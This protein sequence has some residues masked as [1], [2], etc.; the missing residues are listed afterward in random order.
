MDD[1]ESSSRSVAAR[2]RR[3]LGRLTPTERRPA[4]T[5]LSNY[6]VA[7]LETVAQFAARAKVSGPTILRLIAK[8][9]FDSYPD[10]QQAL[11]DELELRLQ[12]PLAKAPP[13]SSHP[14]QG[15]FLSTYT[16]A[17]IEN[18]EASIADLPRAEFEA[19][20]VLLADPRRRILLLGGRF[21]SS[22]AI[23][24][25]L[26]LRELRP[27]V[28]LVEGQ[29]ATLVEHLLDLGRNDVLVVLTSAASR[30]MWFSSRAKRQQAGLMSCS[31]PIPGF[32]RWRRWPIT[33]FR[34][35]PLCPPPGRVSQ[36]C[37]PCQRRSSRACMR[38][39]GR[40]ASG[41]WRSWNCCVRI[42]QSRSLGHDQRT[43]CAG[44]HLRNRRPRARQGLSPRLFVGQAEVGRR[45]GAHE[46][47]DLGART[48]R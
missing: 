7:G 44:M 15:D 46:H 48:D 5:L 1:S 16:R 41:A 20:V 39:T 28:Q 45:P 24:L 3:R 26:H 35:A 17:I 13:E 19:A 9:G 47:D 42:F 37:P 33:S 21:T 27:R 6:P 11:R 34:C 12:T 14:P 22:L 23:H 25:Y 18:I 4:L 40:T 2:I 32:R 29:T 36:P 30:R 10:F 8:L 43:D 31:S 38:N